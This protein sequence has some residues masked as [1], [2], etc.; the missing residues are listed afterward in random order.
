VL[1]NANSSNDIAAQLVPVAST[2]V[3]RSIRRPAFP[4]FVSLPD[5]RIKDIAPVKKYILHEN[6]KITAILTDD[7]EINDLDLVEVGTGYIPRP[8]FV[9]VL[10][11]ETRTKAG[12]IIHDGIIP[13]RVPSL[14]RLILYAY[15]P[16]L[17]FIGITISYTPFPIADVSSLWLAL[18]WRG[19]VSYPATAEERLISEQDRLRTI[20]EFRDKWGDSSLYV[21]SVLGATEEGYAAGLR[22]DIVSARP[23]LDELIMHWNEERTKHRETMFSVKRK[24]L[25]WT[26]ERKKGTGEII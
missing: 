25:E 23:D 4:G 13:Y 10:D 20:Q 14:H 19:E 16:T 17:A 11:P 15:N 24:A 12:P 2:P 7:T 21:Y 18:A 5:E 1:G 9:H 22:K 8:S 6:N 3:Y 26:R